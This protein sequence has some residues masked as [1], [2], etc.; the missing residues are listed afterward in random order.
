MQ[1]YEITRK[2]RVNEVLGAMA[3]TLGGALAQKAASA[4]GAN[5]DD[6]SGREGPYAT[7]AQRQGAA[8][9]MNAGMIK[10]LAKKAQETWATEV[11]NMIVQHK[12]KIISVDQIKLPAIELE[13]Q[14]LINSL[15]GFDVTKLA[16]AKDT[17][18]Q[19][20]AT[21]EKL[22]QA[23]EEVI[24][25][26]MA[27]KTDPAAMSRAWESLATMIAQAQNVRAFSGTDAEGSERGQPAKV[28]FDPA[29]QM[30]YNGKPFNAGD[31]SHVLAQKMQTQNLPKT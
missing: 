3:S 8:M 2:P 11:Q 17:S 26:T 14:T 19:S 22:M 28:T 21:I 1:I 16:N 18:G 7:A 23:K 10:A 15:S 24:K 9:K 13:L 20:Q 5:L 27:P 31:P 25:A 12:P 29:G 30:L 6:P 4:V